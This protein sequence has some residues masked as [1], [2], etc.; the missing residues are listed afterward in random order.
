MGRRIGAFFIDVLV[1]FAV[2]TIIFIPLATKRTVSETLDLPGCHRKIE[3][4][5]Q[6]EC[7]NRVIMQIGDTVYEAD[8]GPTTGLDFVFTFLYFG[9]LQGLTG[10]TLGKLATGIRVVDN[11]GKIANVGRSLVR[12]IVFLVDGPFSLFMCGLFTSLFSKGHR[13][14]GDMAA[15][16]YVVD[17]ASVG[18]P[19]AIAAAPAYVVPPPYGAAPPPPY[20]AAP[21][22]PYGAAPPPP[23]AAAAPQWDAA[24]GEYVQWDPTGN[25]YL[26]WDPESQTWR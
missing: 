4:R 10:A 18:R 14:L 26:T 16:T 21:P 6:I 9:V 15:G 3:S 1:F 2:F 5:S 17:K 19:V 7:S 24:R 13:R 22:P 23:P 12:W 20:G 8:V 11:D 25:R